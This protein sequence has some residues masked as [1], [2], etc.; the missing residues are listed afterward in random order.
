M[1]KNDKSKFLKDVNIKNKKAFFEFEIL[2]KYTAGMSLKGSEIKSIRMGKASLQEAF[3][4][5]HRGEMYIRNMYIAPYEQGSG[6]FNH[7]ERR[8]R[9]LLLKKQEID[10][11]ESKV[12]EKGLTLVPLRLFINDRG[13]AKLELAL[14]KGKKIHD[15]RDSIKEK[16]IKREL[17]RMRV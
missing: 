5:L 12:A 9:K 3:C 10:K 2:E 15:K 11:L 7:E 13:F 14:A 4:V 17:D 6:F 16:D 1:G 8:E